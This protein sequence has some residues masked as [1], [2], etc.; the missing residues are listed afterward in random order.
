VL[1]AS[2]QLAQQSEALHAEVG[3]FLTALK[4]C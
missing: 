3:R 4:A 2:Q 1:E